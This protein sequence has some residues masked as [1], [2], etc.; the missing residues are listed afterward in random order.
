MIPFLQKIKKERIKKILKNSFVYISFLI[1]LFLTS[2]LIIYFYISNYSNPFIYS[3]IE[4]IPENNVGLLLGTSPVT[5]NG[6]ASLFFINR[7]NSGKELIKQEKIKYILVSGDNK[8]LSYNEPK[9][10][11]NYLLKLGVDDGIII[12]DYAGRR[13]LDSVIRSSEIFSQDKITII[14]Q[15]FHNQRAIFIARK[16]GIDAIGFN[17]KYPY[18]NNFENIFTNTWTFLRELLARDLA[19]VDFITNKKPTIL[20]TNIEIKNKNILEIKRLILQ[21]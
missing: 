1:I 8:T 13:T 11:R 5:S 12:S 9:Y 2:S 3:D 6:E 20:G 14:S 17:A 18:E 21:N 19:I 10:M 15:K 16:N 7:M 4:K